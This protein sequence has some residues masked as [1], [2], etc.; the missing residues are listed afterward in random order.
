MRKSRRADVDAMLRHLA[1]HHDPQDFPSTAYERQAL[2]EAASRRRLIEWQKDN[3][4]Y[5]LTPIGWHRL[6]RGWRLGLPS[7]AVGAGIGATVGA[8]ALA[9]LWL[10]GDRSA[11]DRVAATP[12]VESSG[13]RSV[14]PT[15]PASSPAVIPAALVRE[16]APSTLPE[17][18]AASAKV[19]DRPAGPTGVGD[20]PTEP[21]RVADRAAEPARVAD[22]P[23]E[24]PIVAEQ[25]VTAQPDGEAAAAAAKEPGKKSRHRSARSHRHQ[26]WFSGRHYRDERFA[27]SGRLFR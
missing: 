3:R 27:G 1:S 13:T 6:R 17:P 22:R 15:A 21:A 25:P 18:P 16:A 7:L 23:A 26:W 9:M 12:K 19:V 10:P 4:R 8:V 14:A 20:R 5:E 24:P 2:L 11:G